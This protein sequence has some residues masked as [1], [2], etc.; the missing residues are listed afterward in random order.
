[1]ELEG[2]WLSPEQELA[3]A[4]QRPNRPADG[5][6]SLEASSKRFRLEGDDSMPERPNPPK[7]YKNL[8][9]IKSSNSRLF[10][11]QCEMEET[12]YR[13]EAQGIQNVIF[14]SGSG[15][16]KSYQDH[17]AAVNNAHEEKNTTVLQRL[18]HQQLLLKYHEVARDL[19]RRITAWSMN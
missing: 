2:L 17:L 18:E 5:E 8:D 1:V 7:A 12:R 10:R 6:A 16:I 14:F 15:T 11:I 19:S 9:F 3:L 13:F 4:E